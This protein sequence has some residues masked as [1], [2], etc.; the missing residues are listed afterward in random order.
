MRR[1]PVLAMPTR[2]TGSMAPGEPVGGLLGAPGAEGDEG[3]S[4]VD[5]ILAV[6]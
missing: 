4:A 6:L 1:T 3:G 2:M 5:E